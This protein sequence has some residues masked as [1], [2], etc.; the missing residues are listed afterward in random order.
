MQMFHFRSCQ[1]IFLLLHWSRLGNRGKIITF[2]GHSF[3]KLSAKMHVNLKTLVCLLI[4]LPALGS[5][6]ALTVDIWLQQCSQRA[7]QKN[8]RPLTELLIQARTDASQQRQG[9]QVTEAGCN[10]GGHIVWVDA[11]LPGCNDN[12]D[13]NKTWAEEERKDLSS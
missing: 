4:Y 10:G 1:D 13:H 2:L 6:D 7:Q 9:D 5:Q 8:R 3:H 11:N 12:P